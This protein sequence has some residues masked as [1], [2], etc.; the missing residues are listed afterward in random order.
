M[1][2]RGQNLLNISRSCPLV[3]REY[4]DEFGEHFIEENVPSSAKPRRFRWWVTPLNLIL[5]C[6]FIV[7]IDA[8]T[9]PSLGFAHLDWALWPITG[10]VLL[11]V[12]AVFLSKRPESYWIVG[13]L[14]F[15]VAAIFLYSLDRA[16][17]ANSGI[18]GLDW[19]QIPI[20]FIL[21]FGFG[22]PVISR[23]GYIPDSPEDRF[24][25]LVEENEQ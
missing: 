8:V 6:F 15:I 4:Q 22:I 1:C 23:L 20:L 25:K 11:F 10:I 3:T 16:Y 12:F 5:F 19:S 14:A 13:P 21:V 9:G 2:S 18:W 24:K 7:G 17:G